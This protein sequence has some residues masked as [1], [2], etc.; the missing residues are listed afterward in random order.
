MS[1]NKHRNH[2][3]NYNRPVEIKGFHQKEAQVN[4]TASAALVAPEATNPTT[5]GGI[6]GKWNAAPKAAKA[7]IIAGTIAAVVGLAYFWRKKAKANEKALQQA[8][9]QAVEGA[10]KADDGKSEAQETK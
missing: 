2:G 7:G 4:N 8:F 3:G 6:A 9:D 1:H 10:L 5:T